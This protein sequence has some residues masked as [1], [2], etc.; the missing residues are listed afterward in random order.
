MGTDDIHADESAHHKPR[1]V[2]G[3]EVPVQ[4]EQQQDGAERLEDTSTATNGGSAPTFPD[5][6]GSQAGGAFPQDQIQWE[7]WGIAVT[8]RQTQEAIEGIRL[9]GGGCVPDAERPRLSFLLPVG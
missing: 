4:R 7:E 2:L 3:S 5:L 6:E 8:Q 1:P 9:D